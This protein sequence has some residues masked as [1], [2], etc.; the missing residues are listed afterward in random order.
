ME[1]VFIIFYCIFFPSFL[2]SFGSH[3]NICVLNIFLRHEEFVSVVTNHSIKHRDTDM[4][5]QAREDL[6]K[7]VL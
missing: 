1:V 7:A 5:M 6:K 2:S 4:L 3:F